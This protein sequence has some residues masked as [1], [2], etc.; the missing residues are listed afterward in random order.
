MSS[1]IVEQEAIHLF[2][3]MDSSTDLKQKV[4][5]FALACSGRRWSTQC[6]LLS[7]KSPGSACSDLISQNPK[8]HRK[9][10]QIQNQ[11][12]DISEFQ[13]RTGRLSDCHRSAELL[14]I[15]RPQC[16]HH[17]LY[18]QCTVG[19]RGSSFGQG[20]RLVA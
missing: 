11:D 2:A 15:M 18:K 4:F 16:D 8:R 14:H 17:C 10:W 19:G 13:R 6:F 9:P 1:V 5:L 12:S 7:Y 20:A 3:T